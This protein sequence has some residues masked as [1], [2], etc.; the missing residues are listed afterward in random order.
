MSDAPAPDAGELGVLPLL[1]MVGHTRDISETGLAIVVTSDSPDSQRDELIGRELQIVI[2]LP[3]GLT[4]LRC[5]VVRLKELAAEDSEE[6]YLVGVRITEMND[7]DWVH[8][9]RYILTLQQS[10]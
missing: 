7:K 5:T 1:P 9:V 3:D 6:G 4:H 10:A 2:D 8:M